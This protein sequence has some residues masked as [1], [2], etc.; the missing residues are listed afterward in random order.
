ML[1]ET[2][3]DQTEGVVEAGPFPEGHGGARFSEARTGRPPW[4][5]AR[6]SPHVVHL[7]DILLQTRSVDAH[8][9]ACVAS[10]AYFRGLCSPL[11]LGPAHTW[12]FCLHVQVYC[13]ET[14]TYPCLTVR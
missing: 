12:P 13:Y 10:A 11:L 1:D 8:C 6:S 14:A 9:P 2:E 7:A 3:T 4:S 5:P